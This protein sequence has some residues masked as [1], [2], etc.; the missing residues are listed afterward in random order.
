MAEVQWIKF[1]IDMFKHPKIKKLRRLPDGDRIALIWIMFLA[2]AGECNAGGLIYITEN[3]PFTEEDLADEL[4]FEI[5]TIRLAVNAFQ[6]LGMI[7]TNNGFI[8]I[9]NWEKYQNED[10]LAE[11]R[12]QTRKRVAKHR[13]KQKLLGSNVTSNG[14]VT[15]RNGIEG[16]GDKDKDIH[17]F[18]LDEKESAK[19]EFLGGELGGGIV[20]MSEEQFNDLLDKLSLDELHHYFDVVKKCELKGK[21]FTNKTHYQAILDMV[22]KDRK[23]AKKKANQPKI[24]ATYDLDAFE[25]MLNEKDVKI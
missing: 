17:S 14:D 1:F 2:L 22:A 8:S 7:E 4:K 3:V 6:E 18:S 21:K 19:R 15:L 20:L 12:E 13:E 10:K 16:E 5:T 9:L 11:M 24:E 25:R 23:I